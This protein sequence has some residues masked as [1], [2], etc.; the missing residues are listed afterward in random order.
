MILK[1]F[2]SNQTFVLALLLPVL[3]GFCLLNWF[4]PYHTIFEQVNLGLWGKSDWLSAPWIS[5][6]SAVIV[7]LNALQ[8]NALF[9]QHEFL[10]RNN[11]GPS[12]FYVL[13]MSFSHSFY[14]PDG[15]LVVHICW[16]QVL[17]L[18]FQM[19]S[20]E[21]NRKQIT[22]AAFYVGLAAT[23]HP[24]SAGLLLLFWFAVWAMKPFNFRE[25]ILSMIGFLV[26]VVNAL[27]YWWFSGHRIDSNLLRYDII[28]QHEAIVYYSTSGLML[29]L[30][31]LSLIGI[32]I[33]VQKSSI[34]YKK[35]NRAVMWILLG[36]SLLGAADLVFYQQLEWF[37]FIF[38]SLS[39]FFTFAFIHKF[40]QGIA[41][42]FF[43]AAFLLAI[44]KF[45][46]SSGL[47]M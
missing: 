29:V 45:F 3:A 17:R 9:N 43:Y 37:N 27:V 7:G 33:R 41:T 36:G 20:G 34:R 2:L 42:F 35:L 12:L 24:P 40:W 28:V 10:E 47:P 15:L 31:L 26:P 5:V 21:D 38:I 23:F 19:R 22:N 30:F 6:V 8:L 1:P 46:L 4:F 13:L 16:V 25:W 39:F 14:Q 18:L 11:Y 44:A 32:R